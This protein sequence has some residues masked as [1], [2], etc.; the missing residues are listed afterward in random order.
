MRPF[1]WLQPMR[2]AG[3]HEI[4]QGG[5]A[6]GETASHHAL[7]AKCS[8]LAPWTDI[9]MPRDSIEVSKLARLSPGAETRRGR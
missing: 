5:Y 9:V 8:N 3:G 4:S 6:D 1:S 7:S 2:R